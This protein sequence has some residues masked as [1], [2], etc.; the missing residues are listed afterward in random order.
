VLN[1]WE[2]EACAPADRARLLPVLGYVTV[3]GPDEGRSSAEPEAQRE[4]IKTACALRSLPLL[5]IV[6]EREPRRSNAMTRPGLGYALGRITAGEADGLVVADLSRLTWSVPELGRVLEWFSQSGAR[7][8]AAAPELDTEEAAGRFAVSVIIEVAQRERE[9]IAER[10]RKGMRA[11]RSKGPPSIAD[12]PELRDRI[13]RMRAEGLTLQAIADRLN[14]EGVPTVRGGAKWRPSSVQ[15]ATGYRRP[16]R[17]GLSSR[18]ARPN[19]DERRMAL[20]QRSQRHSTGA[21]P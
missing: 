16:S 14:R 4:Q 17:G 12:Y 20:T 6:H 13:A 10:T 9:R 1:T 2:G 7:L 21:A 3:T 19:G 11:A 15:A 8:I 5:E 18:V